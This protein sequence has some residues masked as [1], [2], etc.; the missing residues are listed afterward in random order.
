VVERVERDVEPPQPR[1]DQGAGE[2]VEQDAVRR[3][4]EVAHAR[5]PREHRDEHGDVAPHERLPARQSHLVDAHGGEHRDDALELLEAEHLVALQP[6]ESLGRHAVAAAEVALVGDRHADALDLAAPAV[7]ERFH[8][9]SLAPGFRI[10]T[11]DKSG[12]STL[13]KEAQRMSRWETEEGGGM[14]GGGGESGGGGQGG[15]GG[16]GEG[17]GGGGDQ[18]GGGGGGDSA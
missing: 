11:T 17:G 14:G 18:G 13:H 8:H 7:D 3:Q 1:L 5:R 9:E 15:G 6:L 4:R 10:A 16:G 12:G 2:A